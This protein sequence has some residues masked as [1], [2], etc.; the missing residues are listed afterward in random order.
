MPKN[1]Y[2]QI[3]SLNESLRKIELTR[4]NPTANKKIP[5]LD[6]SGIWNYTQTEKL[7]VQ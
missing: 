2:Q 1:V 6:A 4:N 7:N 5:L 3:A